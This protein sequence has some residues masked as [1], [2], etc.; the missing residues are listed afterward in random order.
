MKRMLASVVVA[1]VLVAGCGG[2]SDGSKSGGGGGGGSDT[3]SGQSAGDRQYVDPFQNT[4]GG[5]SQGSSDG[6]P[7]LTKSEVQRAIHRIAARVESSERK[8][9][10]IRAVRDR[11]C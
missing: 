11:A 6:R 8:R 1:A 4:P 9:R 5:A 2:G 3:S 7:C 10:S